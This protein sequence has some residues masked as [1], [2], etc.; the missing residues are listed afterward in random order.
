MTPKAHLLDEIQDQLFRLSLGR[1]EIVPRKV[2]ALRA[3][4]ENQIKLVVAH[5][6]YFAV[7]WYDLNVLE[8]FYCLIGL[9]HN[10]L[11]TQVGVDLRQASSYFHAKLVFRFCDLASGPQSFHFV[12]FISQLMVVKN[13]TDYQERLR[14]IHPTFKHLLNQI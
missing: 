6:D 7:G 4:L 13:N 2:W 9:F 12:S 11:C 8:N 3:L 10:L 1:L 14:I 5:I